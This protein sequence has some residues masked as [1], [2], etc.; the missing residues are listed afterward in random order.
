MNKLIFIAIIATFF[1]AQSCTDMSTATGG[2]REGEVVVVLDK[3]FHETKAG[4]YIDTVLGAP[5]YGLPQYEPMFKVYM[6]PWNAFSNTFRAF[7]NIIKITISS[8]VSKPKVTVKRADMQVVFHFKAPNESAFVKLLMNNEQQL[9]DLLNYTE[10][11]YA[12][13]KIRTGV[14]KNLRKYTLKNYNL[15]TTFPKGYEVRLDTSNFLWVSFETKDM[16]SGAFI[17][18]FPYEDTNTFSKDYLLNKRDSLLELYVE[19]PLSETRDT[20]MTTEYR[21]IP[22][23]FTELMVE[24]KYYTEIRGLWTVVNDFMGGPFIQI[25][26]LDKKRNRVVV[27]DGYVYNPGG[28]KRKFVRFLEAIG[29]MIKF[30]EEV[31]NGKKSEKTQ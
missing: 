6:I 4:D 8:D 28:N 19:G 9:L 14:N 17:Y 2:G 27:F 29:Y 23:K 26:R 1:A 24:N 20:Y 11:K 31:S 10:K 5:V 25:S 21:Y 15:H 12:K 16:S 3:K 7:R 13:Y 18:H 22:P 30:P